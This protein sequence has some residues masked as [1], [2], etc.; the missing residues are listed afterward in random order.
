MPAAARAMETATRFVQCALERR[1]E[2]GLRRLLRVG[3]NVQ[4]Q[5]VTGSCG[6]DKSESSR[7]AAAVPREVYVM[8]AET[9]RQTCL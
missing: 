5:L 6:E 7:M 3:G 4:R 2:C 1:C 9:R 8:L